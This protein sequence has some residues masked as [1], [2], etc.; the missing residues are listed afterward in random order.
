ME[1]IKN[2]LLENIITAKVF[3]TWFGTLIKL[4][5]RKVQLR[6]QMSSRN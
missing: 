5:K 6:P 1:A 2:V 3:F 4:V